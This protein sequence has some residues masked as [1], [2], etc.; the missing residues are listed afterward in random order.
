MSEKS[1]NVTLTRTELD[2]ITFAIYRL[3]ADFDANIEDKSPEF[4]SVFMSMAED[5]KKLWDKL[6]SIK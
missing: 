5:C 2:I 4:K 3:Y 1:Y 6:D